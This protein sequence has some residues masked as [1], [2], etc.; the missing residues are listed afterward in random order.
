MWLLQSTCLLSNPCTGL[1]SATILPPIC[2]AIRRRAIYLLSSRGFRH[3]NRGRVSSRSLSTPLAATSRLPKCHQPS[4]SPQKNTSY[5]QSAASISGPSR[6]IPAQVGWQIF[7][8]Y[9][10]TWLEQIAIGY[11]VAAAAVAAAEAAV[12]LCTCPS[13]CVRA[14]VRACARACVGA[15]VRACVHA[16]VR[17][18]AS[19]CGW[20]HLGKRAC[21]RADLA[22]R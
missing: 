18:R 12:P 5:C 7:G 20:A 4:G 2:L 1:Q 16:C 13:T 15:W 10:A 19:D 14:C 3:F 6:S 8:R 17:A 22:L 11:I 21:E 9:L